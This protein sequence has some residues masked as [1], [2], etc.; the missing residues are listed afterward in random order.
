MAACDSPAGKH[1]RDFVPFRHVR[2]SG[3][4]LDRFLPTD[5]YLADN[6]LVGVGMAFNF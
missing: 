6:Q 2:R 4:N 3:Y 1:N 5:I